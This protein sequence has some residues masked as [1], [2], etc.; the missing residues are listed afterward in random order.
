MIQE[1]LT[2][3]TEIVALSGLGLIFVSAFLTDI[4]K[5]QKIVNS[6]Q[7]GIANDSPNVDQEFELEE[8]FTQLPFLTAYEMAERFGV[9]VDTI[10]AH[11]KQWRNGQRYD[12]SFEEWASDFD[13]KYRW[14]FFWNADYE[15]VFYPVSSKLFTKHLLSYC[16]KQ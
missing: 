3:F 15:P 13:T 16:N 10:V 9:K 12:Y 4:Q 6:L 8:E 5:S 7:D 14:H 11:A 2:T 1:I